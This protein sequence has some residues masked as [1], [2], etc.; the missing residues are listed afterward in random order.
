V[1]AVAV[2]RLDDLPPGQPHLV[3]VDGTR[4]VLTR[5]GAAVYACADACAHQG[6]PLSEGKQSGVRLACPWHGW[7]YDVRSGQCTFPG[8]GAAVATYSVRVD[9]GD[10]IVEV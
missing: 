3:S 4:I 1:R 9:N 7:M 8:R 6:G 2:A 10:V 5:V